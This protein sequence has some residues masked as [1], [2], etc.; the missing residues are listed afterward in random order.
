MNS[1]RDYGSPVP[2]G[3]EGTD[4]DVAILRVARST[5][6]RRVRA[7][8]EARRLLM[9]DAFRLELGATIRCVTPLLAPLLALNDTTLDEAVWAIEPPGGWPRYPRIG[10]FVAGQACGCRSTHRSFTFAAGAMTR[11][12]FCCHDRGALF[13]ITSGSWFRIDVFRHSLEVTG[14]LGSMR[15]ATELGKLN[16]QIDANLPLTVRTA[17]IGR[18]VGDVIDHEVF[19]DQSWKIVA[20]VDAPYQFDRQVLIIE[21]NFTQYRTPWAR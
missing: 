1:P 9:L 18:M 20:T 19:Q 14:R 5:A 6:R 10:T 12:P 4:R 15:F 13:S 2:V 17:C 3:F 8:D 21:T 16:I 11:C 7:I